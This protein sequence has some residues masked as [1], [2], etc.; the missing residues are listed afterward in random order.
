MKRT[1]LNLIVDLASAVL[2]L[3]MI[4]TG[5]IIWFP[6]P[7][8]SET[9]QSLWGLTRYSWGYVHAGISAGLLAVLL[10]HIVLHWKW[11][12]SV[13]AR[14]FGRTNISATRSAQIG[15]LTALLLASASLFFVWFTLSSVKSISD[16][17]LLG[18]RSPLNAEELNSQPPQIDVTAEVAF[19]QDVYPL[20]ERSCLGCH[21]PKRAAGN[22]RVD[23]KQD[24][25][26]KTR[27]LP[28]VIPG[29]S[30]ASPLIAIVS[31]KRKNMPL[32]KRHKLLVEDI[33]VLTAWID[34]GAN[35]PENQ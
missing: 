25:F 3:G 35:W 15:L 22:F 1:L 19:L 27:D 4:V 34:D 28:F 30:S 8:G 5:Y 16:E 24:F 17:E 10:V 31:G 12:V 13:I 21:G 26:S 11:M 23:R 33:K 20:L 9:T 32:A 18:D 2:L 6:L 29:D 14:R 7:P